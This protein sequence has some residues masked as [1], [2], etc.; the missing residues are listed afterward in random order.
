LREAIWS[1]YSGSRATNRFSGEVEG[2]KGDG[3]LVVLFGLCHGLRERDRLGRLE[4]QGIR[5]RG[6]LLVWRGRIESRTSGGR[7]AD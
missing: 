7:A 5:L 6:D 4:G 2:A 3:L 1:G